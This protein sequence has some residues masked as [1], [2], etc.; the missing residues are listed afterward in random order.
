MKKVIPK[1][2]RKESAFNNIN[3]KD[4]K[5]GKRKQKAKIGVNVGKAS[6]QVNLAHRKGEAV[7]MNKVKGEYSVND[8]VSVGGSYEPRGGLYS[9]PVSRIGLRIKF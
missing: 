2:A 1:P 5:G 9:D 6:M 3:I 4:A 7:K 8:K